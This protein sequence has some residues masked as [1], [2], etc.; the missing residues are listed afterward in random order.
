MAKA[1]TDV[2][3]ET[4]I[5]N[6]NFVIGIPSISCIIFILQLPAMIEEEN[7]TTVIPN[8]AKKFIPVP[9]TDVSLDWYVIPRREDSGVESLVIK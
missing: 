3:K 9:I 8:E 1:L 2:L 5:V 7:L 4:N 6:Q